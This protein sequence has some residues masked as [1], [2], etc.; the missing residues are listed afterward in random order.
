M[1]RGLL[2]GR[3]LEPFASLL[4]SGGNRFAQAARFLRPALQ[5]LQ[6]LGQSQTA[7]RAGGCP[8]SS[9]RNAG[10]GLQAQEVLAVVAA[11]QERE[12]GQ[13][14]SKGSDVEDVAAG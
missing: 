8:A 10:L 1:G 6:P 9:S 14:I 13:V 2:E 5:A 4:R 11:E 7:A 12:A 3:A